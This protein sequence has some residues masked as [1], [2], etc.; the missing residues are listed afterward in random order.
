METDISTRIVIILPFLR[1][2]SFYSEAL[3]YLYSNDILQKLSK[4]A[5]FLE[6]FNFLRINVHIGTHGLLISLTRRVPY[7]QVA[8]S[9]ETHGNRFLVLN[10]ETKCDF[11]ALSMLATLMFLSVSAA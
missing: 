11:L 7:L 5:I 8:D 2:F 1:E 10:P 4:I 6:I 3:L 9:A